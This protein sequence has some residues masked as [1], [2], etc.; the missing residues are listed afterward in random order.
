MTD[1]GMIYRS[2]GSTC[3][4]PFNALVGPACPNTGFVIQDL[5]GRKLPGVPD[6]SFSL[7]GEVDVMNN[8]NGLI[9]ARL[10]YI[11]R[12]DFYLTVFNNS[13]E[14]V[15]EFDFMNVDITY[16]SPDGKW[17]VDLYVH[18]IEDKDIITGAFVG[19]QANGGGYNLFM[20]EPMNGG[21]SIQYNF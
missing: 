21:I 4:Q 16:E 3:N 1:V 17:M 20:Q 9:T 5:S 10:D 15:N 6:I 7:G 12:G 8:D 11:Y 14:L 13:H 19:S 2:L 18:N